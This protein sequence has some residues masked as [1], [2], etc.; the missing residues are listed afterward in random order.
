MAKKT[1]TAKT[2]IQHDNKDYAEGDPIE[3]D[4]KTEAPQLLAVGAIE[5]PAAKKAAE[6]AAEK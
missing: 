1:Y 2:P 5:P 3:L 4:D 6:K